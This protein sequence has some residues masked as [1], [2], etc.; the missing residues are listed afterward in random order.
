ML[1]SQLKSVGFR[2]LM[3]EDGLEALRVLRQRESK[4]QLAILDIDLPKM[5]GL[6]CLRE[7][8]VLYPNLPTILMSGLSSVDPALL[9]TP[10]L[11]K[12]FKKRDLL[13][14]VSVTLGRS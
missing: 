12:P 2:V 14:L 13:S 4:V 3:A 8:G 7:M 10:F 11:R 6:S 9:A 5:D 1:E